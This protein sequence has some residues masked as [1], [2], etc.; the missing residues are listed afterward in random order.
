MFEIV[1]LGT[2][3]SAPSVQRGLS[4][5]V[6]LYREHRFMIDCGEGT[7]R[8][9]LKSG[10]GFRRINKILITHSH[11][12][13]ILGLGGLI[14]TFGRWEMIPE[15]EIF[16]GKAA[17][18]RIQALME[19]VFGPGKMPLRVTY[20]QVKPGI[21]MEDEHFTL[22]AV[23]VIHRGP[24]CYGYVFQEKSKRPFL[25]EKAEEIGVP[26]GPERKQLVSGKPITL[27]NGRTVYPEEVLGPP[28]PGTKLVFIGDAG[29]TAN[30][31]EV[32]READ[33]LVIESTYL[34]K[35]REL[36]EA[37]GHLTAAQAAEL[38]AEANV[39][40]LIL[41]HIS[42]RYRASEVEAE[43]RAIF[44]NTVVANDFDHFTVKR[45]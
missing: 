11:L 35:E 17:L 20:R 38:A 24:D 30:L 25:N 23:P 44:P 26:F 33:A 6:V 7:Q 18:N 4:S 1:F 12:D 31:V 28:V 41:T 29:S 2:S 16:A 36:A 15:V 42:R 10:L 34:E 14:S 45:R 9:L 21:V 39:R 37:F 40:Q 27:E 5:A 13:H 22:F 19:V 43:A 8:Q 3:A 32:S